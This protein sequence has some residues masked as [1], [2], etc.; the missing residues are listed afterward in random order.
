MP[1]MEEAM[2]EPR[3]DV[4]ETDLDEQRRDLDAE[5]EPEAGDDLPDLVPVTSAVDANEADV[6]EQAQ[7]VSESEEY[8]RE[9]DAQ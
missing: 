3:D 9:P 6:W 1:T 2:T 7:A 5:P 4:P 8:P